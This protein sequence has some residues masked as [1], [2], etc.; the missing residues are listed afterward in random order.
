[1]LPISNRSFC[2]VYWSNT[3]KRAF[4]FVRVVLNPLL[5]F[6]IASIFLP[7]LTVYDGLSNSI[8]LIKRMRRTFYASETWS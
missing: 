8:A 2:M 7:A 5:Y 4:T 3:S 6:K 1:M